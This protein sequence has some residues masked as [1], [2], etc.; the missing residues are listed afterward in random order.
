[1]NTKA[2]ILMLSVLPLTPAQNVTIVA[3]SAT[4]A[5]YLGLPCASYPAAGWTCAYSDASLPAAFPTLRYGQVVHYSVPTAPGVYVG[6]VTLVEPNKTAAGQRLLTITVQGQTS[7]PVDVFACAGGADLPCRFLFL[8]VSAVGTI[9]I[10]ITGTLGNAVVSEID[11][12]G[13]V[14][15]TPTALTIQTPQ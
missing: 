13:F 14:I 12:A 2:I 4:D 3:G 10:Q 15:D 8:A 11:W 6:W 5:N 1:M 9:D 7:A